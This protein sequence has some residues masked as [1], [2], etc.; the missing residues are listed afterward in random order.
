MDD[1][2]AQV[3][4]DSMEIAEKLI[5]WT[6]RYRDGMELTPRHEAALIQIAGILNVEFIQPWYAR[7]KQEPA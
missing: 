2:D 3:L 6:R 4:S 5:L 7:Q 1:A